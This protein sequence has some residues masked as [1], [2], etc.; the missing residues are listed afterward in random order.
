[1]KPIDAAL[2]VTDTFV[3]DTRAED[4]A[5]HW[6]EALVQ[7]AAFLLDNAAG[8]LRYRTWNRAYADHHAAA[9]VTVD[10]SDSCAPALVTNELYRKTGEETYRTLTDQSVDYLKHEPR[11]VE[12]LINHNGHSRDSKDYPKSVWVDSLMMAGVFGAMVASD[13]DDGELRDFAL[14]QG[15]L[16][17]KY[18]RDEAGGLYH[19]SWWKVLGRP[20]PRNLFWGRGNGWVILSFAMILE[21]FPGDTETRRLFEELAAALL[22]RQRPDGWFDTVMNRPGDNYRESSATALI[23]AGWLK[24]FNMGILGD[25]YAAAG[26]KAVEALVEALEIDEKQ[27]YPSP[28]EYPAA[29]L[30]ET[31]LGTIPTFIMPYRLPVGPYPG[32]K[33]VKKGKNISWGVAALAFAAIE[34]EKAFDIAGGNS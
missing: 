21:C 31:S 3:R 10:Q 20:Y 7:W 4:M 27:A 33:Y 9:G 15:P 2:A 26:R 30:P 11:L 32:Y 22:P 17:A 5:W 29:F 24:G 13:R 12:G 28:G 19:H 18:L 6:G 25:E 23:A 34:H 14:S 1:M 8:S 16:F